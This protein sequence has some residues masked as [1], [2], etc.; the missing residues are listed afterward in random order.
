MKKEKSLLS[1]KENKE[2]HTLLYMSI[3]NMTEEEFKRL[4][5]LIRK[6]TNKLEERISKRTK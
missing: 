4:K 1:K 6:F 5:E 2:L 3:G